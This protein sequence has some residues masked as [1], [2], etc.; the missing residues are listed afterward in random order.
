MP[1]FFL[2]QAPFQL[3]SFSLTM[4]QYGVWHQSMTVSKA[5]AGESWSAWQAA[6]WWAWSSI[7]AIAALH[8][9]TFHD[10]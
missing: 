3:Q 5:K 9:E 2:I 4:T 6:S 10:E 1:D 7:L 8:S